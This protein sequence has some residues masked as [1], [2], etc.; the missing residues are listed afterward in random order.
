[1]IVGIPANYFVK[2]SGSLVE[3]EVGGFMVTPARVL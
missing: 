1:M 2:R 3:K